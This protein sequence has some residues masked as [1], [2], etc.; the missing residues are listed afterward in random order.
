MHEPE[1]G[2]VATAGAVCGP[3]AGRDFT[4]DYWPVN[5]DNAFTGLPAPT[6]LA[7]CF[8]GGIDKFCGQIVRDPTTHGI[9]HIIDLN[10]NVG[11]LTTSGL[12][13]SAAYQYKNAAGTFRHSV[14]G[15]YLFKNNVDTGTVD[16]MTGKEQI[17]HGRGFFDLALNPDL[18][19][20]EHTS[21]L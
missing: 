6:I 8:Q 20:E 9:S 10:Q 19:S 12:D 17:I 11:A 18:R 2:P 7:Q 15:T 5:I 13:F 16:A 1:K 21:E 14:E 3:L 4:L